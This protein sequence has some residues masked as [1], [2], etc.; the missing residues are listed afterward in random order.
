MLLIYELRFTEF[1][2]PKFGNHFNLFGKNK[3]VSYKS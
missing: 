3:Y 2:Y 1:K